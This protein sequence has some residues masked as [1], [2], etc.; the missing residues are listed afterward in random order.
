MRKGGGLGTRSR[1]WLRAWLAVV[2]ALAG[3]A[4]TAP[5]APVRAQWERSYRVY[6]H[7]TGGDCA[8]IGTW[9]AT[10]KTC[11]LTTDV[12]GFIQV[13]G[14]GLILNGDGH[15]VAGTQSSTGVALYGTQ[16]ATIENLVI[17]GFYWGL[18]LTN[19]HNNTIRS[20]L[21][22]SVQPYSGVLLNNADNNTL[23][24]NT[25]ANANS[26]LFVYN[27]STGNRVYH[28]NI[29]GLVY[30]YSSPNQYHLGLPVGGNHY[31]VYDEPAEGCHDLNA[32]GFCDAPYVLGA[33][34]Q[35]DLPWIEPNGWAN[36]PPTA[37]AGGPYEGDEAEPIQ[38]DGN[39]SFDPN[40]DPLDFFWS[41][42]DGTLCAFDDATSA[43]PELTCDDDG[44]FEVT[45]TVSDGQESDEGKTLVTVANAP[46][47]ASFAAAPSTLLAGESA[48]LTFSGMVDPSAIDTAAGFSYSYDAAGDGTFEVEGS[49][50]PART[51]VYLDAGL[52][53]ARGRIADKDGGAT[54]YSV[55]VQVLTPEEGI[56]ALIDD[57]AELVE[58]GS[59][60]RGQ[61][62]A[63]TV[64]LEHARAQLGKGKVKT[65]VNQLQA[66][67]HQVDDLVAT[68]VLAP[69][70]GAAL[71]AMAQRIITSLGGG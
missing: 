21:I 14:T 63:L 8:L 37:D 47:V 64:K 20:N 49:P 16:G 48:E 40:S 56:E 10:T 24:N 32:D 46:P 27:G 29:A 71:V 41:V 28:N 52:F 55:P 17:R 70:E 36:D 58:G 12:V 38:L 11:T 33:G 5:A 61:G 30:P 22:I 51:F 7:P 35:D 2:V 23:Y 1:R 9:D 39:G 45:L 3:V 26:N 4:V 62:N 50:L 65:A 31:E 68:G 6:D 67:V 53:A 34:I 69:E 60:N 57:V 43:S 13:S 59:L 18:Y 44:A 42:S 25:L 19:A 66:F 54:T 15:E